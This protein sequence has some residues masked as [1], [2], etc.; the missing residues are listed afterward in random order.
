MKSIIASIGFLGLS[1][2][3]SVFANTPLIKKNAVIIIAHMDDEVIFF[4]P[5]LEKVDKILI[6]SLPYTAAHLNILTNY[7]SPYFALWQFTRGI[8]SIE[9]YKQK[10][11]NQQIRKEFI[12]EESYDSMLRDVIADRLIENVYTHSPWGEYGHHHHR[13]VSQAVRRL[14]VEYGKNVWCPNM[15]VKFTNFGVTYDKSQLYDFQ[16]KKY[17]FNQLVCKN[18]RQQYLNE[19]VNYEFPIN[20]WTGGKKEDFPKGCQEYFLAVSDG[21][22]WSEGHPTIENLKNELPLYGI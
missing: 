4:Q 5:V 19:P 6:A 10:W 15:V 8:V 9:E 14:A 21:V 16:A 12:T 2:S 22:D 11:L 20:W 18:I 7:I 1:K 13:Q 3:A 17:R